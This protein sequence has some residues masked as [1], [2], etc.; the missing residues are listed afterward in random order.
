MDHPPL[1]DAPDLR[2]ESVATKLERLLQGFSAPVISFDINGTAWPE[3]PASLAQRGLLLVGVPA[4]CIP[5]PDSYARADRVHDALFLW[6]KEKLRALN[7]ALVNHTLSVVVR[8]PLSRKAIFQL[9]DAAGNRRDSTLGFSESWQLKNL[10]AEQI[11][12]ARTSSQLR[13]MNLASLLPIFRNANVM[14]TQIP[15]ASLP[16]ILWSTGQ[17]ISGIPRVCLPTA[18]GDKF[19]SDAPAPS[20]N[21]RKE[22]RVALQRSLDA[23]LF[24]VLPRPFGISVIFEILEP[25]GSLIHSDM[26]LSDNWKRQH[27]SVPNRDRKSAPKK[28]VQDSHSQ[29]ASA[30][31]TTIPWP[32]FHQTPSYQKKMNVTETYMKLLRGQGLLLESPEGPAWIYVPQM[33]ATKR[34]HVSGMPRI[35]LP[36]VRDDDVVAN[37]DPRQWSDA[38]QD[39]FIQAVGRDL[40]H[41]VPTASRDRVLYKVLEANGELQSD[42]L[43][44][45]DKWCKENLDCADLSTLSPPAYNIEM[46]LQLL[47]SVG[48]PCHDLRGRRRIQW[49]QLPSMLAHRRL[50]VSG[51]PVECLPRAEDDVVLEL[52]SPYFYSDHQVSLMYKAFTS[53]QVSIRIRSHHR[54]VLFALESDSQSADFTCGF[55]STWIQMNL[56]TIPNAIQIAPPTRIIAR[57]L[58]IAEKP[59]K[60]DL[61]NDHST[62][63]RNREFVNVSAPITNP[64]PSPIPLGEGHRIKAQ[65]IPLTKTAYP[66]PIDSTP[67]SPTPIP[68]VKPEHNPVTEK[69]F[70]FKII[71]PARRPKLSTATSS[72]SSAPHVDRKSSTQPGARNLSPPATDPPIVQNK[73]S[74]RAELFTSLEGRKTLSPAADP[75][76]VQNKQSRRNVV[77]A[78]F[79]PINSISV[80]S[81]GSQVNQKSSIQPV[82]PKLSPPAADPPIVFASIKERKRLLL[83]SD[84]LIVRNEQNNFGFPQ[85]RRMFDDDLGRRRKQRRPTHSPPSSDTD[86]APGVFGLREPMSP[87]LPPANTLPNPLPPVPL[88]TFLPK[89]GGNLRWDAERHVWEL[90]ISELWPPE[91]WKKVL[92]VFPSR[93]LWN[94]AQKIW[95][96]EPSK[97]LTP[98]ERDSVGLSPAV[99]AALYASTRDGDVDPIEEGL[100]II[101]HRW[102]RS[103]GLFEYDPNK[104]AAPA[105]I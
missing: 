55:T 76:I 93:I 63:A 54:N 104:S 36:L 14:T 101:W 8:E 94:A 70:S 6:S 74:R 49:L 105:A 65:T 92:P 48:V 9:V 37:Y 29:S 13:S 72:T 77:F 11:Y 96:C 73:Q 71:I 44:F 75:P 30:V 85:P 27:A 102:R 90:T 28:V 79:E 64:T 58:Q 3:L 61:R 87:R 38:A 57:P 80:P 82:A 97:C 100:S 45:S 31:P 35:C 15:W 26:G 40:L 2:W 52:S 60:A 69:Q 34:L 1:Q 20:T 95:L 19:S 50:Y 42:H 51:C 66:T 23:G 84:P 21:W 17:Y 59:P 99:R 78:R 24:K 67:T 22:L 91:E 98:P 89:P 46:W 47:E 12:L 7:S 86:H 4:V 39:A 53:R 33:L 81:W 83:A 103:W 5:A 25:D 32:Q 56:H 16:A 10:F 43:A 68:P 41:V 62:L 88:P 18:V